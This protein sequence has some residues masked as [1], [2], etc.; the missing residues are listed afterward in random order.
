MY[1]NED[2]QLKV[3]NAEIEKVEKTKVYTFAYWSKDETYDLA[4]EDYEILTFQF[5]ADLLHHD[6]VF[7]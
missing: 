1:D 7:A 5:T 3:Y 2:Q 6:F 4:A